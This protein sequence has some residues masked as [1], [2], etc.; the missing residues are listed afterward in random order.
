MLTIYATYHFCKNLIA[1]GPICSR[2]YVRHAF[3][4]LQC[5]LSQGE[6]LTL[7]LP[8]RHRQGRVITSP[9]RLNS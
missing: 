6:A 9:L 5:V 3:G 8:K 4:E 1:S 7:V 2:I